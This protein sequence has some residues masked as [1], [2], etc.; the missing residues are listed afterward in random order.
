LAYKRIDTV[1]IGELILRD[2]GRE[3]IDRL[4][5]DLEVDEEIAEETVRQI[6]IA[7]RRNT[8]VY[9]PVNYI[10]LDDFAEEVIEEL[11]RRLSRL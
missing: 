5:E 10:L 2:I 4:C 3:Y 7:S 9:T 11:K 6:L 1:D 8:G